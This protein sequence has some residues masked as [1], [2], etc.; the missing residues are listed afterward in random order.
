MVTGENPS[1]TVREVRAAAAVLVVVVLLSAVVGAVWGMLA[2]TRSYLVIEPDRPVPFTGENL[3]HF[4]ALAIFVCAGAATGLLSAVGA[5]RLRRMRGPI[6]VVGLVLGSGI[7]AVVMAWFGEIVADRRNPFPDEL[8]V[9]EIV[10]EP[11]DVETWL[12]LVAQPLTASLVM[13]FLAALSTGVDLGTGFVSAFD[14]SR[15]LSP[16]FAPF[17]GHPHPAPVS[18]MVSARSD[19]MPTQQRGVYGPSEG[20]PSEVGRIS[21]V[22]G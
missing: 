22:T 7:G 21:G 8:R 2:P 9:G 14:E 15:P 17:A 3:H 20:S 18:T 19:S 5:W 12:A 4:D 1:A 13:L 10:I 16:E 11:P 6:Q